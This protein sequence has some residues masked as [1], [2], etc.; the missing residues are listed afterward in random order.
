MKVIVLT[1]KTYKEKD[2]IVTAI[3]EEG[4]ITFLARGI[5]DPKS[6][7]SILNNP[8]TIADI[9][10]EDGN[11]KYPVLRSSKQLL[12]PMRVNMDTKYLG[13]LM[14]MNE[15]VVYLFQDE[16]KHA[17]FKCLEEGIIALHKGDDWLNVLLIFLANTTRLGGFEL[18]VNRCVVCGKKS[19]IVAFSFIEGGFIC[20]DCYQE[21]IER[22]LSK[23]QMLLLR[24][25]FN[26]RSY[27]LLVNDSNR[28][29]A[30]VIFDK[31]INFME[32]AFGYHFKNIALL[33]D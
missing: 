21:E 26:S 23:D 11:F 24:S 2:A 3:S 18:E 25:I 13:T 28:Q 8:L 31:L 19:G 32:E 17:L 7:N 22:D 14:L 20:E 29:D 10:I 15:V 27:N 1:I 33:N 30:L 9:E 16:E 6:K 12:T 5:K 4:L